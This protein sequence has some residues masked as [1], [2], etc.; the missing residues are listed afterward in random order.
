MK[1]HPSLQP[2]SRDHHE[3]LLQVQALRL[4]A[5]GGPDERRVGGHVLAAGGPPEYNEMTENPI[6]Y[7]WV[8]HVYHVYEDESVPFQLS[9]LPRSVPIAFCKVHQ[10]RNDTRQFCQVAS[11][12]LIADIP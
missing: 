10:E 6:D 11:N 2:L 4:A 3:A 12:Q 7:I 1:R 8:S 5:E 9:Q